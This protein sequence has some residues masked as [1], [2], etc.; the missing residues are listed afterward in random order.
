MKLLINMKE[1]VIRFTPLNFFPLTF[2]EYDSKS[3]KN[4]NYDFS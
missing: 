2:I 4:L 3:D 1:R